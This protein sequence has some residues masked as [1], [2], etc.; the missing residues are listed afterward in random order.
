MRI[1]DVLEP[2]NLRPLFDG[3]TIAREVVADLRED[4]SFARTLVRT[5]GPGQRQ[6]RPPVSGPVFPPLR[7]FPAGA[8]AGKRIAVVSSG[9]SGATA[10][11]VGVRRAFEEA[12][13]EPVVIS[14]CS[15]SVLFTSL[16]ACGLSS[17]EIAS[18]WLGLGTRDYVDPSWWGVLKA[19]PR[20]FRGFSGI[21]RGEAIERTYAARLGARTLGDTRIPFAAV[22]WDIDHNRVEYL[23]TRTRPSLPL[24]LLARIATSIPIMTDPVRIDGTWYGDGGIVDIFPIAPLEAEE[25]I[26]LVIGINSY[27]P[28]RFEGVSVEGWHEQTWSIVRAA[29]QLRYAIYSAMA[30]EHVR[31]LGDRLVLLH[32]VPHEEVRG[33]RF[34]ESFLDRSGWPRFMQLGY[35]SAR[36]ALQRLAAAEVARPAWGVAPG[37]SP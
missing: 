34:Y 36:T 24:S 14:S 10:A 31:T 3:I 7:P 4:L 19:F 15:G 30:R 21:L 32:P 37:V 17:D 23:S 20:R 6:E 9:G 18:F 11:M 2:N 29:A 27:L 35:E 25:P 16:W 1:T 28:P 22:V 33:A 12:G 5:L 13:V 8:L 26:D